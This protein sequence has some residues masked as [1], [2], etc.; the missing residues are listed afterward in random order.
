[1][2]GTSHDNDWDR[3]QPT[4]GR[5]VAYGAAAIGVAFIV[6]LIASW[7]IPR[8]WAQRVADVV[9]G[10]LTVGALFG[11]FIG[12]VFTLVPLVVAW[13]A[14]R[15]RSGRRTWRGWLGWLGVVALAASPNLMTLGIAAGNS[16]AA[17][18]GDRILSVEGNG[19]RVWSFVGAVLGVVVVLGVCY[20]ARSRRSERRRASEYRDELRARDEPK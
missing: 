16:D 8:W 15:L 9:D 7:T 18:D 11:L 2:T 3:T 6:Y 5:K 17:H 20:L 4:L 14:V 13:L 10:R 12:F 1:M 19:F